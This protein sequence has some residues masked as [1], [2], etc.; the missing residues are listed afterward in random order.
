MHQDT[1]SARLI[2]VCKHTLIILSFIEPCRQKTTSDQCC[3]FPFIYRGRLHNT[4][5]KSGSEPGWCALTSNYDLDYIKDT[6]V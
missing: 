1:K 3:S 2:A 5:I 4:C 6:C